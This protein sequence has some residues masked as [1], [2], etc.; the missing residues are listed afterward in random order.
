MPA[1][2]TLQTISSTRSSLTASDAEPSR[3][4][5]E[6]RTAVT[7]PSTTESPMSPVRMRFSENRQASRRIA[8]ARG[9][10]PNP[11]R[12]LLTAMIEPSVI[13]SLAAFATGSV[14]YPQLISAKSTVTPRMIS[15]SSHGVAR[16]KIFT[17]HSCVRD[18]NAAERPGPQL[19]ALAPEAGGDLPVVGD[20]LGGPDPALH[21]E[22]AG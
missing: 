13:W 17:G 20:R 21:E 8:K 6:N 1:M 4:R 18:R 16:Q 10:A 2:D 22:P 9:K 11:T 3:T 19:L 15:R 14:R 5:P 12:S 7:T